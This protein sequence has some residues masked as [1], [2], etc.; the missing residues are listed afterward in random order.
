MS[1]LFNNTINKLFTKEEKNIIF[2]NVEWI[3][4]LDNIN[5]EYIEFSFL[6]PIEL[7]IYKK[8][9]SFSFFQNNELFK[10]QSQNYYALKDYI[11]NLINNKFHSI[12]FLN[13][14]EIK[15]EFNVKRNIFIEKDKIEEIKQFKAEIILQKTNVE[16]EDIY[17]IIFRHFFLI[18]K[19]ILNLEQTLKKK[20]INVQIII[21]NTILKKKIK[22]LEKKII[23]LESELEKIKSF[24]QNFFN[25]ELKE[26]KKFETLNSI[27]QM[28]ILQSDQLIY[29]GD[30][31]YFS[32]SKNFKERIPLIENT[33]PFE[34]FQ[35]LSIKN[36]NNFVTSDE[37]SILIWEYDKIKTKDEKKK[38]FNFKKIEFSHSD[39]EDK[40]KDFKL[41]ETN[42][43]IVQIIYRKNSTKKNI[44][45]FLYY[46]D[47]QIL[48][49]K[50]DRF[51]CLFHLFNHQKL[52]G[53]ILLEDKNILVSTCN[54]SEGTKFWDLNDNNSELK[55]E[56][57]PIIFQISEARC[58][59]PNAI[60]R[61]D[62]DRIIVGGDH[63][64]NKKDKIKIISISSQKIIHSIDNSGEICYS[65]FILKK[66]NSILIGGNKSIMI[67]DIINY[68]KINRINY[69]GG[70]NG[71]LELEND[72]IV[73][74]DMN[75]IIT[76]WK[77]SYPS[78]FD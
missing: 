16:H 61:L 25:L 21:E 5:H 13:K 48:E 47:I 1:K 2:N 20:K 26:V 23:K 19:E 8:I 49:E 14:D 43:K 37:N 57:L 32:K 54:T 50:D 56:G 9:I 67:F 30:N 51:I 3:L 39:K 63:N 59:Y 31:I 58:Y 42:D 72:L 62:E 66:E 74:Y 69:S 40:N 60:C 34:Y 27:T 78:L 29:T 33:K 65:F 64:A 22:Q 68:N 6:N 7:K 53:G 36:Q 45:V 12:N 46:G 52:T 24:N 75:G 28:D 10:D 11:I 73:S 71:F 17:R 4:T 70:I 76:L 18:D 55:N 77:K 44:I 41:A 35:C 15:F 38:K